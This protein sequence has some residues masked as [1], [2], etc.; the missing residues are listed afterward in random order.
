MHGHRNTY[1][2]LQGLIDLLFYIPEELTLLPIIEIGTFSGD[3]A[4]IF[5]LKF[6]S[7][8]AID[9]IGGTIDFINTVGLSSDAVIGQFVRNTEDKNISLIR[10]KSDDAVSDIQ[11]DFVGCVYVDGFHSYEQCK[12][13]I[14]NYWNKL[15]DG[16]L[17]CGHDYMNQDTPGVTRAVQ[18]LFGEPDVYFID[19]SWAVKKTAGRLKNA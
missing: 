14:L 7:V 10:K 15:I 9:P 8:I 6:P 5:S 19:W 16:G 12:K 3:A 17:M 11:D 1:T 13:D 18:E 4:I 2:Q